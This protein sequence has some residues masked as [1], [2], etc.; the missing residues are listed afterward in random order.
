MK[1][2]ILLV[3]AFLCLILLISAVVNNMEQIDKMDTAESDDDDIKFVKVT[4]LIDGFEKEHTILVQKFGDKIFA[5]IDSLASYYS[6]GVI[7]RFFDKEVSSL[8]QGKELL[9]ELLLSS[10]EELDTPFRATTT[11]F[12]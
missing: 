3:G 9:E 2:M 1:D 4:L 5:E 12:F 6:E 7:P 11:G 10:L 8:L